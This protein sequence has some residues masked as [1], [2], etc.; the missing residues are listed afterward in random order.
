M[1]KRGS[2]L[3][4]SVIKEKAFSNMEQLGNNGIIRIRLKSKLKVC[5]VGQL[6]WK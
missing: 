5:V 2:M 6:L 4:R 1:H 3:I